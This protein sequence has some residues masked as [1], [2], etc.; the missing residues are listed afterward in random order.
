MG[1][2]D[3]KLKLTSVVYYKFCVFLEKLYE[4]LG[5]D[6]YILLSYRSMLYIIYLTSIVNKLFDMKMNYDSQVEAELDNISYQFLEEMTYV[7]PFFFNFTVLYFD[8]QV[9]SQQEIPR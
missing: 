9:H 1:E 2:I 4:T 7:R 5:S 6:K 3:C 8:L